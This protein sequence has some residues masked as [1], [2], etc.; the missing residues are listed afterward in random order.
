VTNAVVTALVSKIIII[1]I[2]IINNNN[3]HLTV[4]GELASLSDLTGNA[5][6]NFMF[7]VGPP[8]LD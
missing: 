4:V 8:K 7:L 6:G 2:I 1:I 3:L 5:G